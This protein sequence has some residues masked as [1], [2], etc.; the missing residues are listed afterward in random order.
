MDNYG[1]GVCEYIYVT[2]IDQAYQKCT[3]MPTYFLSYMQNNS[4]KGKTHVLNVPNGNSNLSH[5]TGLWCEFDHLY[6]SQHHRIAS[7]TQLRQQ[8]ASKLPSALE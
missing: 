1:G 2:Y 4:E 6:S 7:F 5:E 3:C 8:P